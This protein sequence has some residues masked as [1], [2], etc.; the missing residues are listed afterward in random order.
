MRGEDHMYTVVAAE[1]C[2]YYT[3]HYDDVT[4]IIENHPDIALE[5]QVIHVFMYI[6]MCKFMY[7]CTY[8]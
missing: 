3:L 4:K 1:P 7:I 5:L 6:R 2:Q 8:E